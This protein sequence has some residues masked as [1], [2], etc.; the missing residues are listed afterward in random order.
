MEAKR[1]TRFVNS[2][3]TIIQQQVETGWLEESISELRTKYHELE[4]SYIHKFEQVSEFVRNLEEQVQRIS[5]DSGERFEFL[6]AFQ[7]IQE[8]KDDL[9][10]IDSKSK[11]CL[12]AAKWLMGNREKLVV[13]ACNALFNHELQLKQSD[14]LKI[15]TEGYELFRRDLI[16]YFKWIN[17]YLGMGGTIPKPLPEALIAAPIEY[18]FYIQAFDLMTHSEIMLTSSISNGAFDM[19]VSYINR[20]LIDRECQTSENSTDS[21]RRT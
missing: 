4:H 15:S 16:I 1:E 14:H 19:L 9:N 20:F 3:V 13:F 11:S 7:K 6:E 21:I 2:N 18:R 8:F 5:E 17:H 10:K 12:E